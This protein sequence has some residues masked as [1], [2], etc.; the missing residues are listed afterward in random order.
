MVLSFGEQFM[1]I[2]F[3]FYSPQGHVAPWITS[4]TEFQHQINFSN[5]FNNLRLEEE[6]EF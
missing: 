1:S 6:I 2:Y 3:M 5:S 4:Q